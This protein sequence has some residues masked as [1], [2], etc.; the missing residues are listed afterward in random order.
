M[1]ELCALGVGFNVL[2]SICVAQAM[3]FRLTAA[4][5]DVR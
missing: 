4:W 1:G 3:S 5:A 2:V